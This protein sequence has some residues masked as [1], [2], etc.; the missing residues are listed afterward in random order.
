MAALDGSQEAA[1]GQHSPRIVEAAQRPRSGGRSG[2]NAA[3]EAPLER[4][5]IRRSSHPETPVCKPGWR[6]P[7]LFRRSR[8]PPLVRQFGGNESR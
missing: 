3:A 1:A 7:H 6:L 5:V 4:D 8:E 2:G